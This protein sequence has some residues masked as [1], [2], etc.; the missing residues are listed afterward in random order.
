MGRRDALTFTVTRSYAHQGCVNEGR[1]RQN[2]RRS[3]Q[4]PGWLDETR[5]GEYFLAFGSREQARAF[6][7]SDTYTPAIAIAAKCM[8]RRLAIVDA[9]D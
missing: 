9:A 3:R 8:V 6:Y 1:T 4:R 2:P 7:E 5:A